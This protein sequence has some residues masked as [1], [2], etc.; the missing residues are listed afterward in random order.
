MLSLESLCI[1]HISNRNISNLNEKLNKICYDKVFNYGIHQG[2][3]KWNDS[4]K[5]LKMELN[6]KEMSVSYDMHFDEPC[7]FIFIKYRHIPDYFGV[8]LEDDDD[9]YDELYR[10][11]YDSPLYNLYYNIAQR[12]GLIDNYN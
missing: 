6:V 10:D 1:K 12:R 4:M 5:T 3:S 2:F 9:E 7:H 8:D 11:E